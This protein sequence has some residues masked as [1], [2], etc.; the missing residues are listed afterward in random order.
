LNKFSLDESSLLVLEGVCVAKAIFCFAASIVD[1]ECAVGAGRMKFEATGV[2]FISCG[3]C[4]AGGGGGGGGGRAEALGFMAG[5]IGLLDA[6]LTGTGEF[7]PEVFG[8]TLL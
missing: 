3:V 4:G 2:I 7:L 1:G 8:V 6:G 5:D